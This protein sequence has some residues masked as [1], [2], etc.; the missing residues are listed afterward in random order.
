MAD[1]KLKPVRSRQTVQDQVYAQLRE[2]LLLAERE[3]WELRVFFG[4]WLAALL[5]A[6]L[7]APLRG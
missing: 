7:R 4:A 3:G 1:V 6:R 5:H 2:A